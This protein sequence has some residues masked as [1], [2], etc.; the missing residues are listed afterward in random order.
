MISKETFTKRQV[1]LDFHTSPDIQRIGENFSKENFQ[2]ALRLGSV[3]SITVFAKCHHGLCYY[4][5]REGK[6]HPHLDFDLTGSMVDAAQE[7]G[8]RAPIYITAGWSDH[9][10]KEHPEWIAKRHDGSEFTSPGYADLSDPEAPKNHCA[11]QTLCLNDGNG[12]T[13]HIYRL[14][15]EICKRYSKVDGLFYDICII[16]DE[17]YCESCVKGMKA[18][19]LNPDKREDAKT[20][21]IEKRRAFMKKCGEI[22]RKYHPSATIF[23]N[24]GGANQYKNA[25]HDLQTH[26]EM[27]DLPTAWGGYNKLPLRA[28]F[29]EGYGKPTLAMTGKFHLDWGEFGGFKPKEA[30]KYEIVLMALYGVG[31]SIGDHL[32]PDGEMEAETYRNIGFAYDYI[33]KIAAYCYGGKSIA[34]LGVYPSDIAAANEGIS[35]ILCEN[36]IDYDVVVNNNFSRY[37]TVIFS[38]GTK[39][40]EAG[41][42]ELKKYLKDGGKLLLMADS[43]VENGRFRLDFGVDYIG[44][45]EYDC[46]YISSLNNNEQLPFAPMLCNIPSHRVGVRSGEVLAEAIEPYFSRTAA[47]FCGHKNTP[48]NKASAKHPAIV[49]CPNVVYTAHSLARQYYEYGSV[50]HKRYFMAAL[51]TVYAGSPVK[52]DGLYSE[53]RCRTIKQE[54]N[55]RYCINL[56]YASPSRRGVSEIIDDITPLYDLKIEAKLPE[57]IKRVYL[58]LSGEQIEFSEEEGNTVFTIKKLLCHETIVL[59]Y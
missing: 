52:V 24:S 1:H 26:Y 33:E 6:M 23:F 34:N 28:K 18:M 31:A 56:A 57:R 36:Q 38:E 55:N 48:H 21:F 7:I 50:Y 59:E 15:E 19:G 25:Y 2:S 10:A 43:L 58:P 14:T 16:H 37:D 8:V 51:N 29:F 40:D 44:A 5:T 27:E 54:D 3:E 47:H 20:Y 53:G 41:L 22:M 4:P 45:S 13:E 9:D 12:Y 42:T 49:K 39:L 32:H 35:N 30:L 46:D 11:W 17:C